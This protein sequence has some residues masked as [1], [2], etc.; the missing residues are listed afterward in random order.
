[1]EIAWA[2]STCLEG[3]N[4]SLSAGVVRCFV[5]AWRGRKRQNDR[6][7]VF[8]RCPNLAAQAGRRCWPGSTSGARRVGESWSSIHARA[9]AT[10]ADGFATAFRRRAGAPGYCKAPE[11]IM[12]SPSGAGYRFCS[13]AGRR[14]GPSDTAPSSRPAEVFG[15]K[16]CAWAL[17]PCPTDSRLDRNRP[18]LVFVSLPGR[19]GDRQSQTS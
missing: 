9:R 11:A 3:S 15:A 16:V 4:P 13:K 18:P 5:L 12:R 19:C 1:M 2:G 7:R 6:T 14:R 10:S 8:E 17:I